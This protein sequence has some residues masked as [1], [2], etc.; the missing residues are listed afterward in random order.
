MRSD[1]SLAPHDARG[2][3]DGDEC[4]LDV[5]V[6]LEGVYD[7]D[8]FE[9]FRDV[10]SLAGYV[11]DSD[12]DPRLQVIPMFEEDLRSPRNSKSPAFV[13][14]VL[15]DAIPVTTVGHGYPPIEE[16]AQLRERDKLC[17][18]PEARKH[19]ADAR[20]KIAAARGHGDKRD[21]FEV[22]SLCAQAASETILAALAAEG[23]DR[24]HAKWARI[25][26][27]FEEVALKKNTVDRE[28][29][30]RYSVQV[31]LSGFAERQWRHAQGHTDLPDL[32][33]A[34]TAFIDAVAAAYLPSAEESHQEERAPA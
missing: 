13:R 29:W 30:E 12:D 32:F 1:A 16:L 28:A 33:P 8:V 27:G 6:V 26:E 34:A 24:P 2:D 25:L 10:L 17:P 4:A 18:I 19:I 14:N 9:D 22:N 5:A 3:E 15:R 20:E 7:A 31:T 23:I 11:C 21:Y